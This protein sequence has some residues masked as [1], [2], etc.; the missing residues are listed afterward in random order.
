MNGYREYGAIKN[1][2]YKYFDL[3]EGAKHEDFIKGLV[4]ILKI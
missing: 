4:D 1:L 2:V 3:K